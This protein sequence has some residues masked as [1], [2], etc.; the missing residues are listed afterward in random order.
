MDNTL[1]VL[2]EA[3]NQCTKNFA[4][5]LPPRLR[6]KLD[7]LL[8]LHE[9][10]EACYSLSMSDKQLRAFGHTIVQLADYFNNS[11]T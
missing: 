5:L 9:D 7:D 8:K 4:Q 6:P 1:Y 3:V 2:E 11:L 10:L